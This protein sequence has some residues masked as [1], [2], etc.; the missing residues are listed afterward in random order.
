LLP[1]AAV[2]LAVLVVW[3]MWRGEERGSTAIPDRGPQGQVIASARTELTE[4]RQSGQVASAPSVEASVAGV[5]DNAIRDMQKAA[6]PAVAS[7]PEEPVV[8][9]VAS[10]ATSAVIPSPGHSPGVGD[11][12]GPSIGGPPPDVPTAKSPVVAPALEVLTPEEDARTKSFLLNLKVSGV[13]KDANGYVALVDG[14]GFKKGDKLGQAEIAEISS[15]RITFAF[16]GKRYN[17]RIP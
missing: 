17:L 8:V 7:E 10:A 16:K 2:L 6:A 15:G 13:Y 14:R 4:E 12:T 11:S 3:K 9:P 5:A 1:A